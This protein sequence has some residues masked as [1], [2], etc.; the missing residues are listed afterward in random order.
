MAGI[1]DD[2]RLPHYMRSPLNRRILLAD[3]SVIDFVFR[4]DN[5]SEGHIEHGAML[6]SCTRGPPICLH[7]MFSSLAL[8]MHMVA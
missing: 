2:L 1:I 6:I 7:R 4:Q 3:H 8:V 5:R